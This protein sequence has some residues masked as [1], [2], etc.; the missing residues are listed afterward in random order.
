MSLKRS[1]SKSL[2][3]A[4]TT[5][6]NG[7]TG[8]KLASDP[9]NTTATCGEC[10]PHERRAKKFGKPESSVS[11]SLQHWIAEHDEN[12]ELLQRL[13]LGRH[14]YRMISKLMNDDYPVTQEEDHRAEI[15]NVLID[16]IREVVAGMK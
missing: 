5:S 8:R 14:Q 12:G 6:E 15:S 13:M 1:I 16:Q 4:K 3:G 2:D 7:N 10:K 11:S 9:V